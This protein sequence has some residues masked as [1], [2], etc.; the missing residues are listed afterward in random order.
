MYYL[1]L[2]SIKAVVTMYY[3]YFILSLLLDNEIHEEKH[4][5]LLLN[6]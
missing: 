4:C 5:V 6:L 3:N 1:E 2:N